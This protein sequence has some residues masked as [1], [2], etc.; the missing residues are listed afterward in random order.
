MAIRGKSASMRPGS[1][2][3]ARESQMISL[4]VDCAEKQMRDGTASATVIVHYLKLATQRERLECQILKQQEALIAAKT[5][6]L[7]SVE[8]T[9]KL[10]DAAMRAFTTYSGTEDSDGD[11]S[12]EIDDPDI[13]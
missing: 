8:E 5:K 7:E 6:N 9:K 12:D 11:N 4:A 13:F 10:L 1:T 3:D 2:P